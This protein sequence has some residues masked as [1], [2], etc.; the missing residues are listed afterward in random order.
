LG[1]VSGT[2]ISHRNKRRKRS[3]LAFLSKA[4]YKRSEAVMVKRDFNAVLGSMLALVDLEESKQT[5]KIE[6]TLYLS[7]SH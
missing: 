2:G 7:L 6:E 4:V 1:V 5:E 3:D